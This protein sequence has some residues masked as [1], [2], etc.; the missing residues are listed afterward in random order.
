MDLGATLLTMLVTVGL[1]VPVMIFSALLIYRM[2]TSARGALKESQWLVI[3]K[4]EIMGFNYL[5]WSLLLFFASE[6]FCGIETYILMH[7]HVM[8]RIFH[9]LTSAGGMGLFAMGLF[10][11]MNDR[12]I[13]YGKKRCVLN[14]VCKGCTID[15]PMDC[16]IKPVMI[17]VGI[18][19]VAASLVC[20]FVSTEFMGVDTS[21]YTLPFAS[22]NAWYDNI[23]V[24]WLRSFD[25]N[26]RTIDKAV[27]LPTGAQLVDFVLLPIVTIVLTLTGLILFLRRSVKAKIWGINFTLFALGVLA[28]AY[29][30]LVLNRGTNDLFVGALGHE[31]GELLYLFFLAEY[32]K[33][34]YPNKLRARSA[35]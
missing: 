9:A 17:I 28:Y 33:N 4:N 21:K 2:T 11:T 32:L 13:F 20:F 12:M 34:L 5:Y 31:T 35:V 3:P 14:T 18:A 25:P 30:E 7:T 26:Y 16:K 15:D 19:L 23:L 24:P 8:G 29:Y 1:K 6:I 27:F 10:H 22:L